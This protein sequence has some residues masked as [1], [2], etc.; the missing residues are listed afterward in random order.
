M[1]ALLVVMCVAACGSDPA[2]PPD[3]NDDGGDDAVA[4]FRLTRL[5]L[6]GDD[7]RRARAI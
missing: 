1:R 5:L 7:S 4:R 3:G 6:Q 2:T